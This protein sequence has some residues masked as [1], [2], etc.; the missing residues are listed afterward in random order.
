[1]KLEKKRILIQKISHLP[2]LPTVL[3]KIIELTDS[4]TGNARTLGDLLSRDPSIS[5]TILKLVNSA[6]YGNLRHISS[7]HHATVILGFEMVK[8]IAMGVSIFN[9][10][11]SDEQRF[12]RK[13]LW[14]HSIGVATLARIMGEKMDIPVSGD[15]IFLSGLIHDIGK[16][17]F[18]NYFVDEYREVYDLVHQQPIWIGD[19]EYQI[20]GMNH[21]DAGFYLGRKWQFPATV[22]DAI[23]FHHT[24]EKCDE[25]NGPLCA[26]VQAADFGCRRINLG[27]GGGNEPPELQP[28]VEQFGV[29][30]ALMDDALAELE[31]Q[32]DAV[33]SFVKD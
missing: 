8:T 3:T 18:D 2:T 20:L 11:G 7:I 25:K 6:F 15:T 4:R 22:V 24:L 5:S 28:E 26:L 9:A 17:V 19:A 30:A 23:R 32:R 10:E 27:S 21:C 33:E 1:M 31:A 14:T 16:V 29:T 12:D 13:E